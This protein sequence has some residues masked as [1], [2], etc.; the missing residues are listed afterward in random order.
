MIAGRGAASVFEALQSLLHDL[1]QVLG[2]RVTL[3]SLELRRAMRVLALLVALVLGAAVLLATA[4]IAAWWGVAAALLD[5]GLARHW[6]ALLVLGLNAGS[7]IGLLLYA[8]AITPRL[9]LPATVRSL[10]MSSPEVDSV[11]EADSRGTE[12]P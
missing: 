7:A 9:A 4:W 10:T 11:A 6:V 3:L 5:A 12:A 8:R 1:P 2:A